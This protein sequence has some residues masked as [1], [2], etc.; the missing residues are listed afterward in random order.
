MLVNISLLSEMVF[1]FRNRAAEKLF[2]YQDHEVLGQSLPELH[3]D[4]AHHAAKQ[5]MEKLSRG[6]SWSGQ[7]PFKKR[8]GETFMA[9]ITKSPLYEAGELVGI[10][11]VS[12]DG[13][14]FNLINSDN[15]STN[16]DHPRDQLRRRDLDLKKIQWHTKPQIAS[17]P[18]FA[19]S[20]SSLVLISY[21]CHIHLLHYI[22]FV[23]FISLLD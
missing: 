16:Q 8:S 2:G 19:S 12:V 22:P 3:I 13:A 1:T 10:I 14:I 7:C 5:F 20:V 11:T 15:L 18:Q 17:V 4:E 21:T 9:L 23:P 6:K